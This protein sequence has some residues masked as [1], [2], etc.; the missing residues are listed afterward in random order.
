[1]RATRLSLGIVALLLGLVGYVKPAHAQWTAEKGVFLKGTVVTM[2]DKGT[3]KK[4]GAVL[5]R[6]GKVEAILDGTAKPPEGAIVIDTKGY[7]FPGMLNLHNHIAYNFLPLYAVP[8]HYDNRDQWPTGASYETWVNNPKNLVTGPSAYD[9]QTEAL[10]Y[11]EVKALVGGETAIQGSPQ[12]AGTSTTLVRNVELPNFGMDKIGQRGLSI[13]GMFIEDL[14]ANQAS[15]RKLTGWFFHLAEGIS[16]YSRDEYYNPNY[17]STLK[18]NG[19]NRPGLKNLDLVTPSLIGI[20]CT[21]LKEEDFADWKGIT[22]GGAKIVWSPVSNFLLY[23]KTTDIL[24]AR[25]QGATVSIGTDWAPSGSKNLLWELKFADQIN[26]QKWNKALTSRELVQMVT[27]NPAKLVGW[28]AIVGQIKPGMT[29]DLVVVDESNANDPYRNLIDAV[30]SKVQLVLI[31]GDPLYGDEKWLK[32]TKTYPD[33]KHYELIN[34]APGRQKAIDIK[35][36]GIPEGEQSLEDIKKALLDALKY[37]PQA[38]ADTLNKGRGTGP[39]QFK[40]REA[41]KAWLASALKKRGKPVPAELLDPKA[42]LSAEN[43]KLF[44][45]YKYP[46]A[47]PITKLD[48]IYQEND[49]TWFAAVK[50]NLHFTG[51]NKVIDM[52]PFEKYSTSAAATPG[53]VNT[54]PGN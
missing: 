33:G 22:G 37:D 45:N 51:A 49:P 34:E 24:G 31:G 30:E 6:G 25:R 18:V 3:V 5:I 10:K 12:D 17:K 40:Q 19:K 16:Q 29:A 2:D 28:E 38:L 27:S 11:A 48:S 13:D 15:V 46:N 36:K 39:L 52:K 50:G 9:R 23:G 53:I 7:I 26:E 44:L 32:A 1:M 54:V 8:K 43:A 21:G 4:N 20:H 42:P 14:A 35:K 47:K 41:T